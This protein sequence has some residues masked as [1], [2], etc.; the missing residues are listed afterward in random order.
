M[1][2]AWAMAHPVAEIA[3]L[4]GDRTLPEDPQLPENIAAFLARQKA[5][6]RARPRQQL[7]DYG[8]APDEA[9]SDPQI[10]RYLHHFKVL[11]AQRRQTGA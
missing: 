2:N 1:A 3:R 7:T 10:A 4:Y 8:Y 5:G 9:R 6:S 11:L